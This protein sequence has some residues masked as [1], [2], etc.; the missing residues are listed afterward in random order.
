MTRLP[1]ELSRWISTS[2]TTAFEPVA[3]G[4]SLP[5][6]VDGLDERD[7]SIVDNDHAE[8][9]FTG[10]FIRERSNGFFTVQMWVNVLLQR[11]MTMTGNAYDLIDWAGE[12]QRVM[13]GPIPVYKW[14][15]GGDLLGC[16]V[17]ENGRESVKVYHF[18]QVHLV[19]RKRESEVD[20]LYTLEL[21]V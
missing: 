5:Y 15:S 6:Y 2:L 18:G 16:L 21:A 11:R 12:F 14:G 1:V 3:A 9:R 19:D 4:L 7:S 10:P 17:V 8:L 13:L 20:A